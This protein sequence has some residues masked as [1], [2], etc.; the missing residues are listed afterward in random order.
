MV[1]TAWLTT[2]KVVQPTVS[3]NGSP[4]WNLLN[5]NQ[6][7]HIEHHDF[8]QIPWSRMPQL[9]REAAEFYSSD[10]MFYVPS[11]CGLVYHW[12]VTKGD[13]MNFACVKAQLVEPR[14]TSRTD[15]KED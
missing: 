6:L 12:L 15:T 14:A 2:K 1:T 8:S 5:F 7:Y 10:K 9:R 4:L 3:Y 11:I 13:K